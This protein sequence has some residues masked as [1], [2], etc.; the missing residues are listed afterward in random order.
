MASNLRLSSLI[1]AGLIIDSSAE[2]DGVVIV[3]V[4]AKAGLP[5]MRHAVE[6]HS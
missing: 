5:A 6:P 2:R 4:H 3:S 1:T